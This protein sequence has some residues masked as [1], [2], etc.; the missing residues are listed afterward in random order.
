MKLSNLNIGTRLT[1]G[2]AVVLILL[3]GASA[4][5]TY[6]LYAIANANR[7][8][9]E[10]PLT[11]EHLVADWNRN[12]FGAIRRTTAIVKSSDES[13]SAFFTED[14]TKTSQI[15]NGILKQIEPLLEGQAEKELYAGISTIRKGYLDAR[16]TAMREKSAGQFG[17]GGPHSGTGIPACCTEV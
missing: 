4:F 11:K 6:Q 16:D 14:T 7:A 5:G 3:I 2:F 1:L 17:G 13:L 12:V 8:L 10:K 15:T 9:L